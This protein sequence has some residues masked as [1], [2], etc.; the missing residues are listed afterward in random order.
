[1]GV[2]V[3]ADG[4]QPLVDRVI[5]AGDRWRHGAVPPKGCGSRLRAERRNGRGEWHIPGAY[6]GAADPGID[7]LRFGVC[8]LQM[9]RQVYWGVHAHGR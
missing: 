6:L 2:G 5:E 8:R 1:V 4:P 9:L 7:F 3:N